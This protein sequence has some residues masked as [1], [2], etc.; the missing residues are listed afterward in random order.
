MTSGR[1]L[2]ALVLGIWLLGI[3]PAPAQ[4]VKPEELVKQAI[5][6]EKEGKWEQALANYRAALEKKPKLGEARFRL[7][8]LYFEHDSLNQAVVQLESAREFRYDRSQV[9]R[10]LA[11]A[12]FRTGR[13]AEAIELYLG[14]IERKPKLSDLHGEL[15]EVYYANDNLEEGHIQD[16]IALQLD[17][18]NLTAHMVHGRIHSR[19]HEFELAREAYRQALANRPDFM[20]AFEGLAELFKS[21]EPDSA[22]YYYRR[23]LGVKPDDA[24]INFAL[25]GLYYNLSQR[26]EARNPAPAPDTKDT[27]ALKK[28]TFTRDSLTAVLRAAHSESAFVFVG[29]AIRLGFSREDVYDFYIKVAQAAHKR[30]ASI[31]A[32]RAFLEINARD[33]IKWALLGQVYAD[34]GDIA[35][36]LVCYKEACALDSTM[37]RRVYAWVAQQYYKQKQYDSSI[38]YYTK[39]TE[40]D[41]KAASAFFSRG[42]AY[43][44]KGLRAQGVADLEK[45]LALDAKQVSPR[46]YLMTLYYQDKEYNQAYDLAKAILEIAP[47]NDQARAIKKNIDIMRAPKPKDDE[48]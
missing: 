27:L 13:H 21:S 23:Y 19:Q 24:N 9:E 3:S 4:T 26:A 7:G 35:Q 34:S 37:R 12:Y 40:I 14:L 41:P 11:P 20:P 17:V 36:S 47:D 43:L 32:L 39:V 46:V 5:A 38:V 29:N 8:R 6:M 30:A 33:A 44:Q 16:S 31:T 48:E 28:W 1:K 2:A 15:A 25:S 22:I 18:K 10:Q 45:G 42:Y